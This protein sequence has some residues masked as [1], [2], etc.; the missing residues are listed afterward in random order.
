MKAKEGKKKADV[1]VPN[2][3][4]IEMLEL[5]KISYTIP[6]ENYNNP[7]SLFL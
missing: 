6:A 3:S 1:S 7:F 5:P 2:W 4:R